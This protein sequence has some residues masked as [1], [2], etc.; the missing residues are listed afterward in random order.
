MSSDAH[1]PSRLTDLSRWLGAGAAPLSHS[2]LSQTIN[3]AR[4]LLITG[5]VFLH[6]GAFP[7]SGTSPFDGMSP[8]A[9]P[10]ATFISSFILFFFFSA[11]PLLSALS[12]WLYFGFCTEDAGP[13]L[14][15]RIARR[16]RTLYLPLVFW[17][18]LYLWL[19]VVVLAF[20]PGSPVLG[21]LNIQLLEANAADF[22]NAVFAVTSHPIGFQFWFL[23]D[24]MVTVLV[25]PILWLALRHAPYAG[26]AALGAAWLVG[27]DLSLFFRTDV[28]F[29]FY[30]GGFLR[31]NKMPLEIGIRQTQVLVLAYL[32]FVALRAAAPVF[33]D[34]TPD[35]PALL[36]AATRAMRL[37]GVLACW[38]VCQCVA[39]TRRGEQLA[40]YGGLSFFLFATH[41][42]LVAG[43]KY[44]LWPLLP[45][46]TDFWMVLHYVTTVTVTALIGLVAAM[47]LA[48]TSPSVFA[49]MN[50]GRLLPAT[51]PLADPARF[52]PA[53]KVAVRP[54]SRLAD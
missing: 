29:F 47:F 34:I 14:R 2:G 21:G 33:I 53:G 49:L 13:A 11:V 12:G 46:Q 23:R 39:A 7:G 19:A 8:T 35:R 22:I 42:P 4:I 31:L 20:W 36:D 27:H 16:L 50:G 41:Y 44:L 54:R 40:Q 26:M 30:L 17:N 15:D 38:G 45:A 25:S 5:L 9:H 51:T 24:L 3:V 18:A 10:V 37:V 6:Y 52:A 43:V 1:V 28:A 48:R 32:A